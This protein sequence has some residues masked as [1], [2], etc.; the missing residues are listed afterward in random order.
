MDYQDLLEPLEEMGLMELTDREEARD[1][2]EIT[3][4]WDLEDHLVLSAE[5]QSTRGGGRPP[6]QTYQEQ[7][8]STVEELVKHITVTKEE[9]EIISAFQISLSMIDIY[10]VFNLIL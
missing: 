4:W 8:S 3:V 9:E 2:K 10:L 5:G 1:R 6:V 7:V